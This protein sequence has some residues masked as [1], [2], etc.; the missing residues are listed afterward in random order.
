MVMKRLFAG[1]AAALLAAVLV[2]PFPAKAVS[3]QNAILLD[4][5]TKR[6]LYEKNCDKRALIASTTKIMTALIV[7]ESV[8]F[9]IVCRFRRRQ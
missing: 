5:D 2:F 7:C 4:A 3:A 6:V 9:W 8:M 1:M